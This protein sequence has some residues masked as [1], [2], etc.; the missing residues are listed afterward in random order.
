MEERGVLHRGRLRG[1]DPDLLR[2]L[3][4]GARQAVR[5]SAQLPAGAG[6]K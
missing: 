1:G 3:E 5:S 2:S 6:V 4:A